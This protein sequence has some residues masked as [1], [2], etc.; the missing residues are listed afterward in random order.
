VRRQADQYGSRLAVI[1]V[2]LDENRADFE[3]FVYNRH[4][5]GSQIF[6]GG[7]RGTLST[8]YGAATAGLPFAVLIAPDGTIAASGRSPHA[9]E[10]EIERLAGA[11]D[12][13]LP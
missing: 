5:P 13:P 3:A 2:S 1:G 7:P 8:L 4:L 10:K 6:D 12:G 11:G 9:L